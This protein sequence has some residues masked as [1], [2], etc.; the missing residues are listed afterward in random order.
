M[1]D[2]GIRTRP[3]WLPNRGDIP[4]ICI[5]Q[6]TDDSARHG[7]NQAQEKTLTTELNFFVPENFST[8]NE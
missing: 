6:D 1:A 7:Q 3:L 5:I 8:E 4:D 2:S